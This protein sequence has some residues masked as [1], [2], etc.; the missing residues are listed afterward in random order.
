[1]TLLLLI[2]LQFRQ[3]VAEENH[4]EKKHHQNS[5]LK[6]LNRSNSIFR[7][8]GKRIHIKFGFNSFLFLLR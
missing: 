3:K 5:T 8:T 6:E 2:F 7:A 4:R 1:M